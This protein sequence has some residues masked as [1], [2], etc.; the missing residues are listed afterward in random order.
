[1]DQVLA[2]EVLA[3]SGLRSLH[4]VVAQ[5]MQFTEGGEQGA[6]EGQALGGDG[7][8]GHADLLISKR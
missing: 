2:V 4:P 8:T 3:R 5:G 6:E 1:M 7:E